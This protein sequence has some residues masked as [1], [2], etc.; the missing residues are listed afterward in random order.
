MPAPTIGNISLHETKKSR[1]PARR[2]TPRQTKA[3]RQLK[4]G[5]GDE[6]STLGLGDLSAEALAANHSSMEE[7]EESASDLLSVLRGYLARQP[8]ICVALSMA[9]G[10][11]V[12]TLVRRR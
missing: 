12:G 11:I 6:E 9:A 3:P 1:R 2:S 7:M 10:M 4:G 8:L 5:V